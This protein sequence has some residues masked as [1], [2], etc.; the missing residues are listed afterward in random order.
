MISTWD[1]ACYTH[2]HPTLTHVVTSH[3]PYTH[4]VVSYPTVTPLTSTYHFC[5]PVFYVWYPIILLHP[6]LRCSDVPWLIP[7]YPNVSKDKPHQPTKF[8]RMLHHYRSSLIGKE[9]G[10]EV[11]TRS[12]MTYSYSH[13][14]FNTRSF[15]HIIRTHIV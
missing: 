15:M 8:Q 2:Q 1:E 9:D 7:K 3:T 12:H 13:R 5:R 10:T 14:N 11:Y 6:T 4:S